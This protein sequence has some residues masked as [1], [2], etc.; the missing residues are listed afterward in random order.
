MVVN[1]RRTSWQCA[2]ELI[3]ALV[4]LVTF[5]NTLPNDFCYDDVPIVQTNPRVHQPGQWTAIWAT[6]YWSHEKD[7]SPAR[8]LLYRPVTIGSFRLI[9]LAFGAGPLPQRIL[10]LLL[11]ALV[12]LLVVRLGRSLRLPQ[13]ALFAAGLLFAVLPIHTE[14]VASLV[15]RS[16]L[17]ASA[18]LLGCLLS[19]RKIAIGG[20]NY[21]L[22]PS[23]LFAFVALS[24]KE[25]A[26]GITIV[27]PILDFYW[28]GAKPRS[29]LLGIARALLRSAYILLPTLAYIFLRY[30]ALEGHLHQRPA[31]SKTVNVL[32]DAP[33]RQHVLGV[34]QLWGMYWCKTFWPDV[35]TIGYSINALRLAND[36]INPQVIVGLT[37]F[38]LLIGLIAL[39]WQRGRHEPLVLT[40]IL[41]VTYLPTSNAFV[42]IQVFFAERIWYLP[43]V[44]VSLLV[45]GLLWGEFL[46]GTNRPV[47]TPPL[48]RSIRSPLTWIPGCM[49][50]FAAA[51]MFLRCILRNGEWRNNG[52]LYAA[53]YRDQPDSIAALHLYGLWLASHEEPKTGIAL[54]R[55]AVE[56]DLGFTDAHRALGQAYLAIGDIDPA[57]QHLRTAEMQV[58]H[59]RPTVS[60]LR[61]AQAL[62]AER[63]VEELF[64]LRAE[65]DRPDSNLESELAF[66]RKFRELRPAEEVISRFEQ[67]QSRFANRPEWWVEFAVTYVFLDKPDAAI[68]R[69]RSALKLVPNQPDALVELAM[70]LLERRSPGDL[71]EAERLAGM[72]AQSAPG[73]ATVLV[74]LAEILALRGNLEA[75]REKYREA[76]RALPPEHDLRR[77][78]EQRAN[79]LG[80]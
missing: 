16:D 59:H 11:H 49:L 66:V 65:A 24:A 37:V 35:L 20:S 19:H 55:R 60:A 34:I 47:P 6:D 36:P 73:Q 26:I 10:N 29:S 41:L 45:G 17:V 52:T 15:G 80:P 61:R 18:G 39:A 2:P 53:A 13:R 58:P 44:F 48:R 62:L 75:A 77:V 31:V 28:S 27:L 67:T 69:Y 8:D 71:D 30:I 5:A 64:R 43:S 38:G 78:Y 3:T 21:W 46:G 9:R 14:V 74:C 22:V 23:A 42:L 40:V 25:S 76:I 12:S 54:L 7:E 56:I 4:S 33:F 79:T 32:V 57:V 68:E 72:A 51:V 1:T 70:L 50:V 63:D